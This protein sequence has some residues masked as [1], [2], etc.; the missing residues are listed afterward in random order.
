MGQR[1]TGRWGYIGSTTGAVSRLGLRNQ[2]DAPYLPGGAGRVRYKF[3]NALPGSHNPDTWR[4]TS[5]CRHGA[6]L[7]RPSLSGA[8]S[9]VHDR[10]SPLEGREM[11]LGS[12]RLLAIGASVALVGLG[13]SA[14]G[15][16]LTAGVADAQ[17]QHANL[18]FAKTAAAPTTTPIKHVVVIFDENVSF[19]HYFA[20]YPYA[21]N[22]GG[23]P[24]YAA[25]GTPSVNGL[26]SS[27]TP[28]SCTPGPLLTANPNGQNPQR[29]DPTNVSDVVTCDQNHDYTPEQSAFD[30][31]KM[32][33]FTSTDGT[34]TVGG[35]SPTGQPCVSGTVL[36]YY[37]GNAVTAEWNYPQ[38]FAMSDNNYGSTF[39]PSTE[40]ALNVT[41]G[42]TG[43]V[44]TAHVGWEHA[45]RRRRRVGRSQWRLHA[46]CRRLAVLGRL[47]P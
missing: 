44:D 45:D 9:S 43:G 40:G 7:R 14:A 32:D 1:P 36:D 27:A 42:D 33:M 6:G 30:D 26:C 10:M 35:T 25:P 2:A 31:G 11:K 4:S 16:A 28:T 21:T 41:S 5:P 13:A 12:R 24:F 22:S 34:A 29:L 47:R 39:G 37:D 8:D 18:V 38:H 3:G 15:L 17:L 19:D 20:T 23:E 46:H